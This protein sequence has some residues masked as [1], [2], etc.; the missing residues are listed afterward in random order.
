MYILTLSM[1]CSA[2]NGRRSAFLLLNEGALW[3]LHTARLFLSTFG[4][5]QVC[6]WIFAKA[7]ANPT[8]GITSIPG[9]CTRSVT[10]PRLMH[11]HRQITEV[12][13]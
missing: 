13:R 3:R 1:A 10:A 7:F 12:R 8:G 6:Q 5:L 9:R 11:G 2:I 4:T